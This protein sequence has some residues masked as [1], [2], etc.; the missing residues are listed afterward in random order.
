MGT[1]IGE[2]FLSEIVKVYPANR[3]VRYSTVQQRQAVGTASWLS[4]RSITRYVNASRWPLFSSVNEW[5]FTLKSAESMAIEIASIIKE[6]SID[7]VWSV[8]SSGPIITLTERVMAHSQVPVVSTILD[9]P[10]YFAR[11]QYIDPF[12]WRFIH[13]KFSCVLKRSRRVSVIS[14]SMQSIYR[15]RYGIESIIMR[16]GIE[17]SH[18]QAWDT[19]KSNNSVIKIGFAGSLY[20]K[21]EWNA[22]LRTLDSVNGRIAGKDIRVTFIGRMP[23][24]GVVSSGYVDNLGSMSFKSALSALKKTDI[25]YLPY[26]F[27]RRHSMTVRTSFPGKI[28]TYAACGIPVLYHGPLKSSVTQFLL[29]Y[30]FGVC[31]HAL[32]ESEILV[33]IASLLEDVEFRKQASAA[34]DQAL[35]DELGRDAML[36]RFCELVEC[37]PLALEK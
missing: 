8:L 2:L 24:M 5:I 3:L 37:N 15:L 35:V 34:R 17:E 28:S 11:N 31:C 23:R 6:E 36:R 13:A 18:F 9:D 1:G 22:L 21:R 33:A 16:H 32:D 29:K 30:R 12:T 14:E 4:F 25:A 7:I 19:N 10:Q 27:D 20:A 26:W